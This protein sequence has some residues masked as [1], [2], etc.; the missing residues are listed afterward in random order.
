MPQLICSLC[1][2]TVT[3]TILPEHGAS[4]TFDQLRCVQK[5]RPSTLGERFV[6]ASKCP[7]LEAS[8]TAA[9]ERGEF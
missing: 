4:Y 9:R 6:D 8:I 7:R 1:G 5:S 3:V 2:Q